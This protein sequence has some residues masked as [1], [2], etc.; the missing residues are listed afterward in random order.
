MSASDPMYASAAA[1]APPAIATTAT[2][3]VAVA[4]LWPVACTVRDA[5]R[6]PVLGSVPSNRAVTAPS[7]CAIG[8]ITEMEIDPPDPP[9]AEALAEFAPVAM[10]DTSPPVLT[11]PAVTCA[12]VSRP[13]PA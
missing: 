1:P 6:V 11:E 12:I 3:A 9:G 5:A 8:T 7:T 2:T 13:E 10:T 4:V